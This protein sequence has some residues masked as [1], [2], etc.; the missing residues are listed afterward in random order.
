VEA[1]CGGEDVL[2]LLTRL[3]EKSLVGVEQRETEARY[4]L[5]ETT[6]SY[7]RERLREAEEGEELRPRHAGYFLALAER[8]EPELRGAAQAEWLQRLEAEHDNFRAA[9]DYFQARGAVE[10]GLRLGGAL[11]WFWWMRGYLSE[12]RERLQALLA[13]SGYAIGTE[14]PEHPPPVPLAQA[15][16]LN[17][18][19]MLADDQND[20]RAAC[21]L[22]QESLALCRALDD[23]SGAAA[24]LNN[25]GGQAVQARD[26]AAARALYEE[27]LGLSRATGDRWREAAALSNMGRLSLLEGEHATARTLVERGLE[28]QRQFQDRRAMARSLTMLGTITAATGDFEAAYPLFA[29]SLSITR[30]LGTRTGTEEALRALGI[31]AFERGDQ[32]SAVSFHEERLIIAREIGMGWAVAEC[33]YYLGLLARDRGEWRRAQ[34]LLAESLEISRGL[35]DD[36]GVAECL[37]GLGSVAARQSQVEPDEEDRGSRGRREAGDEANGSRRGARLFGAAAAL[38]HRAGISIGPRVREGNERLHAAVRELLGEA[39]FDAAWEEGSGMPLDEA[40]AGALRWAGHMGTS[41]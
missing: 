24:A 1:I 8:A 18:A 32:E 26:Y 35:E 10:E 37:E 6:R 7:A 9:L 3:V 29:E 41:G 30:E 23:Q 27:C 11:G 16:A 28:I 38:R 39:A 14:P 20:H 22:F 31:I 33:L 34:T 40:I 13:Q 19:G 21:A 12:G 4:T 15:A 5:L 25:L 36:G 17:L 2:E